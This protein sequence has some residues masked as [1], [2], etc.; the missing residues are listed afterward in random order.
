MAADA[1]GLLDAPGIA[2]AHVVGASMGAMIGQTMTIE[3]P[4]R[5][6]SL[7]SM[8]STTGDPAVGQPDL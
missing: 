1:I 7:T 3:Y 2:S 8:M 6:R 5:V 4:D